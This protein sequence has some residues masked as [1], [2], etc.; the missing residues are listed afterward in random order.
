MKAF[1]GRNTYTM[2]P[3]DAVIARK[4]QLVRYTKYKEND[5]FEK[6]IITLDEPFL[7]RFQERHPVDVPVFANDDSFLLIEKTKFIHSFVHSLEPYYTGDLQIDDT[8]ADLKREELLLI[9]LK[10]NPQLAGVF[11]N[12][13]VPEKI[14]LEAFMNRN[15]RFNISLERFAYLT[16][17]SLSSFKRDFQKR[18]G[19]TPYHWLKKKRLDE[20]HFQLSNQHL[21][22]TQVYLEVGFEDLSHFSFAFKQQ[23]GKTPTEV[24][25]SQ[26][27]NR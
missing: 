11:F 5:L 19:T 14:N 4:N 23:F 16:G 26:N 12:F 10:A 17:R 25:E 6:I 24:A 13:S 18:F 22:P 15:F 2:N 20:A 27:T 21:K 3:G 1:D 7:R 9:L 8:F